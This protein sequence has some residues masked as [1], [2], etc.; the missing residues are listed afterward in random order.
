MF[1]HGWYR[2]GPE[3]H[4]HAQRL[5]TSGHGHALGVCGVIISH[6]LVD[7]LDESHTTGPELAA[8]LKVEKWKTC[9]GQPA[10][11]DMIWEWKRHKCT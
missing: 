9:Y 8:T 10:N 11:I 5:A 3:A 7:W 6:P 2:S 4:L 1:A